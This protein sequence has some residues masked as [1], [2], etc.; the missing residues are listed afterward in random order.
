MLGLRANVH[1]LD[2]TQRSCLSFAK[3]LLIMHLHRLIAFAGTFVQTLNVYD[4]D[5]AARIFDEAGG[6]DP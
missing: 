2:R 5:F 4:L 3:Q 6:A 1:I